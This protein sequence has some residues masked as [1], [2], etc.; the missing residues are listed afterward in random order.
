MIKNKKILILE[1]NKTVANKI[2]ISGGGRCN[3][4]NKNL[5]VQNYDCS[6]NFAEPILKKY[7][8]QHFLNYLHDNGLDTKLI[9]KIVKGQYFFNS[10]SDFIDHLLKANSHNK[11]YTD[12]KVRTIKYDKHFIVKTKKKIFESKEVIVASGGLSYERVGVSDIGFQIAEFFHHD[13]V[14]TG[15][16]LVGFTVQSSE[17]WFKDLSGISTKIK[18]KVKNKEFKQSMLFTHKGCSGPAILNASLYWK[19]GKIE[20]DFLPDIDIDKLLS[21]SNKYISTILPLPKKMILRFLSH[22][23]VEDK[24]IN[25]LNNKEKEL[26]KTLKEYRFAPAGTFGLSSAEVTKGGVDTYDID[27]NM[28][29][30]KQKGLYF[31]GEVLDVTGELGGYNFQWAYSSACAVANLIHKVHD[32]V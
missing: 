10:S 18:L 3:I 22:I 19:K 16:G 8:N 1:Q 26:I 24:S 6:V 12:A 11:I 4:T 28:Q 25:S 17:F 20:V 9:N 14:D 30:K 32:S 13:I 29:S 27:E 15:A 2:K 23:G 5:S 31:I 21:K 7:D